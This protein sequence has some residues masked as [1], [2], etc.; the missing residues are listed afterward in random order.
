MSDAV[1]PRK[2]LTCPRGH[3]DYATPLV[4]SLTDRPEVRAEACRICYVEW[5]Q[6]AFPVTVEP[7][8][9]EPQP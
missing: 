4:V 3:I 7:D 9:R 5:H 1:L 2:K 8:D 6:Q